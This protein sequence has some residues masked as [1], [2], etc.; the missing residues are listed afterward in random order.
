MQFMLAALLRGGATGVALSP[1]PLLRSL[2]QTILAPLLVGVF[3]R[4]FVPGAGCI[5]AVSCARCR[6]LC[7]QPTSEHAWLLTAAGFG[8]CA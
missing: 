2:L 6:V 8:F 4:A 3:A 5:R 1:L 7:Q